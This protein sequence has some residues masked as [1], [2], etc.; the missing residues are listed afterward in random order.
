MEPEASE[1]FKVCQAQ[2]VSQAAKVSGVLPA[3]VLKVRLVC[4]DLK[5]NEAIKV[6]LGTEDLKAFVVREVKLDLH[7][8]SP[9]HKVIEVHQDLEAT[10]AHQVKTLP[11]PL[12]PKVLEAK[13]ALKEPTAHPFPVNEA[14]QETKVTKVPPAKS[15]LSMLKVQKV[16]KETKVTEVFQ[17]VKVDKVIQV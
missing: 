4:A 2:Q 8:T 1:V 14:N 3:L 17:A 10:K 16:T 6:Q 12:D 5:V 15:L 9:V 13:K 11:V 7:Q